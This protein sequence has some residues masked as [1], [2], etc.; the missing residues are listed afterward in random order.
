MTDYSLGT[1][2]T[3]MRRTAPFLVFRMLV[4]FGIAVAY[5][6]ATGTGAGIGWGVGAFGD[7]DFRTGTTFWGGAAGFGLTAAVLYLLREYILYM[8]KAGHIAVMVEYLDGRELPGGRSQI[9]YAQEI[10][11]ARFGEANVLFGIDQL[12][13]GVIRA[14][15]GLVGGLAS[16]LPIPAL[17]GLMRVVRAFLRV[18]VGLIDEVILAYLIRTKSENPWSDS[19]DALV[20]YGQNARPLLVNAAVITLVT[21]VLAFIVF[22]VMLAPAAAVVYLIPGAWSAGG[23][24]FAILFA[25]AVKAAVL[26]PF[27]LACLLQAYF[28]LTEGQAPNPEWIARLEGVS[29]K[30]KKLGQRGGEWVGLSAGA[31]QPES[32]G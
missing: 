5:V 8:V 4:Y 22:L 11:R 26:E 15:T 12:V 27:A 1:S 19:R 17:A 23:F 3:I 7:V 25:W 29:A 21:Y 6:V 16:L 2:F 30:F 24:V 28:K 31:A 18:A 9:A 20:L 13:R 32:K 14:I 10:V